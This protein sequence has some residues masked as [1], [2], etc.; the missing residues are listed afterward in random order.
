MSSGSLRIEKLNI[1]ACALRNRK[2]Y[3]IRTGTSLVKCR[4]KEFIICGYRNQNLVCTLR[5]QFSQHDTTKSI[6][7]IFI[8]RIDS[9]TRRLRELI[10]C[11]SCS[12]W[13][14]YAQTS[15]LVIWFQNALS[16]VVDCATPIIDNLHCEIVSSRLRNRFHSRKQH[17]TLIDVILRRPVRIAFALRRLK[18]FDFSML[19]RP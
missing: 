5:N 13:L 1:I 19:S 18:Q 14:H 15:E 10:L 16:A 12:I 6:P 8:A 11:A 4:L 3:H 9:T 2:Q 17:N 7:P